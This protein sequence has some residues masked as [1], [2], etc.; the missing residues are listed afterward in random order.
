MRKL[1][2]TLLLAAGLSLSAKAQEIAILKYQG[3]GDWYA[4]PTALPNLINF[5]NSNIGTRLTT[6]PETV[7]VGSNTIYQYPFLHMTGHGNVV[8]SSEEKENLR[9]Y[10]LSGGFL[11]I[12]DNYGMREYIIG[13]IEELFPNSNLEEIGLDHP[14]FSQEYAF[15]QGLPKIHEHDGKRPQA[16]GIFEN[17]RLVLLLTLESDLGD[18]WEDAAVHNDPEE[19]RIK[20]LQMGAN[21]VSY[22]FK[23]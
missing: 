23:N 2:V 5:C 15:P 6:K 13:E 4:N 16:L 3:G 18:G 9:N 11:H 22:V 21:I 8:F 17:N 1:I 19:I 20:A 14:I 12:D 10:L 7:E